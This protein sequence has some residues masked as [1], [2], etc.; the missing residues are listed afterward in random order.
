MANLKTKIQWTDAT[1]SPVSG[2][3]KVSAGCKHCYAERD[4]PR[5]AKNPK[6]PY[7]GRDF[8]DV[9][10]HPE[11]LDQPLRW[12][13]PRRI[14][15]NSMSDLFH[16]SVPDS[17]IDEVFAVMSRCGDDTTPRFDAFDAHQFQVLTK[18]PARMRRYMEDEIRG[19]AVCARRLKYR[20]G[21]LIEWPPPNVWLGVSV[22]DQA[23]ADERI[24]I[25]LQTPA[26]VRF[27]SAEPLL[28]PVDLSQWLNDARRRGISGTGSIGLVSSSGRRDNLAVDRVPRRGNDS[29]DAVDRANTS[30]AESISNQRLSASNVSGGQ[31]SSE[32][33]GT[34]HCLDD[35]QSIGYPVGD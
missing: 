23:T 1:W 17:F 22:E 13:K 19:S 3:S 27:V 32:S 15:V 33:S 29:I 20:G 30:G 7:F 26:A 28:N 12:R 4:W 6:S 25:L 21:S 10:C 2:C 24:P 8:T 16:E 14:F 31:S 11:R 9:R 5:L 18:R 35:H 34:P